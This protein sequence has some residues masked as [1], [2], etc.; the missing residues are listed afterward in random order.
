[1]N[2]KGEFSAT[3]RRANPAQKASHNRKTPSC[4]DFPLLV[5]FRPFGKTTYVTTRTT[6]DLRL[7]L[8]FNTR[9]GQFRKAHC[10]RNAVGTARTAT[11]STPRTGVPE[12]VSCWACPCLCWGV[13]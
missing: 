8:L 10:A 7:R 9:N 4:R 13:S 3:A 11:R 2:R 1:M 6:T 12:S 5:E